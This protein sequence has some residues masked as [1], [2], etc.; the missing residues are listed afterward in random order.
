MMAKR[1]RPPKRKPAISTSYRV[2]PHTRLRLVDDDASIWDVCNGG[3]NNDEASESSRPWFRSGDVFAAR[4]PQCDAAEKTGA[5]R[6]NPCA[7]PHGEESLYRQ[8]RGGDESREEGASYS[9]GPD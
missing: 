2:T 5:S 9:G 6:A 8:W 4:S 1:Q 7:N 3:R